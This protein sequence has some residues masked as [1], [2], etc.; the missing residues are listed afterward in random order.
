MIIKAAAGG[1]GKCYG[2]LRRRRSNRR[3]VQL[4]MK[5]S[6]FNDGRVFTE[7]YRSPVS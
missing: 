6:S 2:S 1:G 5:L 3:F 7:R 4:R